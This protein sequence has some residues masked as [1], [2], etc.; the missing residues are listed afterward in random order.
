MKKQYWPRRPVGHRTR[1]ARGRKERRCGPASRD[2]L[3]RNSV[4]C[5]ARTITP[6]DLDNDALLVITIER[7]SLAWSVTDIEVAY[8]HV[9]PE[10]SGIAGRA[11]VVWSPT[12]TVSIAAPELRTYSFDLLIAQNF[13]TLPGPPERRR[14]AIIK[15]EFG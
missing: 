4:A 3:A 1:A 5:L 9:H 14:D 8:S 11:Q 2:P 6:R 7:S 12:Y 13:T 15:R 10:D